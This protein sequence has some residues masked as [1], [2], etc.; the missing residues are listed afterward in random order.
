MN[1]FKFLLPVAALVLL[2]GSAA[3]AFAAPPGDSIVDVALAVNAETGEFSILVAALQ[4]AD[5]AVLKTLDGNGQFTV[6]APTDA[7]FVALLDEL[8]VSAEDLLGNQDLL[9]QVLLYHVARG[10]RGSEAV[11]GSAR[12]RTLQRGFLYQE[13][14]VLTDQNGRTANIIL[15]DVGAANGVIHVIDTVVLP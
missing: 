8:G 13:G 7:A 4:A 12:I 2:L 3:P 15:P 10:R 6:F 14:G 1:K 11:L 9:T 5:P